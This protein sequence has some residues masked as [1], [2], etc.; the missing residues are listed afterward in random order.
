LH[1]AGCSYTASSGIWQTVWLEPVSSS[2]SIETIRAVPDLEG[3]VLRLT[4]TGRVGNEPLDLLAKAF[5]GGKEVSAAAGTAG[6]ELWPALRRNKVEFF[7]NTGSWFTADLVL[8]IDHP[9]AWSPDA[10]FLYDL[11]ITLGKDGVAADTVN[12]YFGMRSLG[13]RTDPKGFTRFL[14]NGEP[15]LMIGALDQGFWPDGIHTAATDEAL[16]RD[17]EIAKEAGLNIIR[18]HVK[19]EPDRFY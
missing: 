11:N 7:R 12:G 14:L 4:V 8:R 15:T 18:K 10:P 17:V 3:G 1:P 13:K 19:V 2:G 6:F 16:R 5:D 9:K